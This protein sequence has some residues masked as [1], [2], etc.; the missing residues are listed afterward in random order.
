M[1]SLRSLKYPVLQFRSKSVI[2]YNEYLYPYSGSRLTA[3]SRHLSEVRKK[4]PAYSG[5]MTPGAK[6][7]LTKAISLLIQSTRT[8]EIYNPVS[9]SNHEF[10]LSFLT[11]TI[12]EN[13]IKPDPKFCNKFLL[14]PFIRV[15]RRRYGLKNYV[16]KLELQ[17]NGM[18]HYHL[19]SNVFIVHTDLKNEWNNILRRNDMLNDYK[20]RT[21]KDDP[22][23]TDIHS[24]KNVKNLEAY[25]IKYV[26]KE[27]Q[28]A[29]GVKTKIWDCSLSLKK[30]EYFSIE[31]NWTYA[32]RLKSLEKKGKVSS[33]AGD[34]YV[35]FRFKE[36]PIY[37]LLHGEERRNYFIH[38]NNIRNGKEKSNTATT[39]NV[40]PT[41][42][43]DNRQPVGQIKT[44][45]QLGLFSNRRNAEILSRRLYESEASIPDNSNKALFYSDKFNS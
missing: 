12:P 20:L 36:N 5:T 42:L 25:L 30:S 4:T 7:R 22:N 14:E 39:G 2:A 10:K 44:S 16:W 32:D 9:K 45:L 29:K 11:L 19:T 17:G 35:I 3:L 6:K 41:E 31:S 26:T 33:F 34:R 23:S 15:L 8:R 21:G 1:E 38:L 24:V 13:D 27:T 18:V 37:V 43:G 28:N 40:Q